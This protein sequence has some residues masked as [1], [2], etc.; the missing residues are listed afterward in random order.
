MLFWGGISLKVKH[1]L[2]TRKW[3]KW[4]LGGAVL[5]TWSLL[6]K[7]NFPKFKLQSFFIQNI[8]IMPLKYKASIFHIAL[9]FGKMWLRALENP[10]KPFK[11]FKNQPKARQLVTPVSCASYL[12]M[13]SAKGCEAS[14]VCVSYRLLF[15]CPCFF[16]LTTRK[17]LKSEA[18]LK[19]ILLFQG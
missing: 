7:R 14:K 5:V 9:E 17:Q 1:Q 19:L 16:L 13:L 3:G 18:T 15:S 12:G 8:C 11:I 4:R 10:C 6:F 2:E